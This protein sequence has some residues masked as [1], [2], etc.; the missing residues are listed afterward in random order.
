MTLSP[1]IVTVSYVYSS[2]KLTQLSHKAREAEE[3]A[4]AKQG[5]SNCELIAKYHDGCFNQ[6]YRAELKIRSF[7]VAEYRA[8]IK[9]KIGIH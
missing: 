4:C 8:C 5:A 9:N 2:V 3:A 6:S 1:G 7:H